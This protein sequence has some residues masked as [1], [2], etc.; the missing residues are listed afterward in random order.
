MAGNFSQ[1]KSPK[2]TPPRRIDLTPDD[3]AWVCFAS[4]P[5]HWDLYLLLGDGEVEVSNGGGGWAVY[6]RPQQIGITRWDGRTPWTI[7]MPIMLDSWKDQGPEP[8]EA[9]RRKSPPKFAGIRRKRR[10]RK[11]RARWRRYRDRHA[12]E[13]VSEYVALINELQQPRDGGEPPIIRI[14]GLAMPRHLNGEKFVIESI[15][16]GRRALK[17]RERK[18]GTLARQE[19]TI[20]FLQ[21]VEGDE[22]RIRRKKQ[23]DGKGGKGGKSKVKTVTAHKDDT[24]MKIAARELGDWRRWKEIA[25]LNPGIKNPRKLKPGMKVKVPVG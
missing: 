1:T 22:L 17:S 19:L 4:T 18:P 9:E 15:S 23:K 21:Y 8:P 20:T 11:A 5:L 6:D 2:Y 12:P 7:T 14:Y 13:T 24:L 16:W 3:P 25:E 10:R